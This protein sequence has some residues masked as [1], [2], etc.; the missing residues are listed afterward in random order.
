RCVDETVADVVTMQKYIL[1]T[2]SLKDIKAG[3][4]NGDE[5]TDVFDLCLMKNMI[6]SQL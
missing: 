1:G 4:V 6:I 2:E 3:D 5:S